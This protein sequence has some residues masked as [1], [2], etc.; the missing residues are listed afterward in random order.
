MIISNIDDNLP[1]N[2]ELKRIDLS[3]ERNEIYFSKRKLL[4]NLMKS[5]NSH[6]DN[7]SQKYFLVTLEY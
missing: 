2:K 5:I 6:I 7:N 1:G 4:K 3:N